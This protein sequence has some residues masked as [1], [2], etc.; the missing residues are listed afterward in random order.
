MWNQTVEANPAFRRQTWGRQQQQPRRCKAADK[1]GNLAWEHACRPA[2]ENAT[3][4]LALCPAEMRSHR[5]QRSGSPPGSWNYPST[6]FYVTLLKGETNLWRGCIWQDPG[7]KIKTTTSSL[8]AP[9]W[10]HP[11]EKK[12]QNITHNVCKLLC[13]KNLLST[14]GSDCS[15]SRAG[16]HISV[17]K[18]TLLNARLKSM[19]L[20]ILY[21]KN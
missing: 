4:A 5:Q 9:W 13:R 8:F 19:C 1:P 7:C 12:T 17:A 15:V 21:F 6:I 14:L 16:K 3:A 20:P 10:Y 2:V 11:T 18:I